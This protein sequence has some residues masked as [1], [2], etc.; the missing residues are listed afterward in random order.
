MT[1]SSPS[2]P[3]RLVVDYDEGP[4]NRGSVFGRLIIALPVLILMALICGG[5]HH[6][7][8]IDEVA[9]TVSGTVASGNSCTRFFDQW[10][11]VIGMCQ[12]VQKTGF[13]QYVAQC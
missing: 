6:D 2:Y 4:R 1:E 11:A 8:E 12:P 7:S 5:N 13:S 10:I 9:Q 3:V